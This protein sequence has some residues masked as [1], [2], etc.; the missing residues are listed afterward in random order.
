VG[1]DHHAYRVGIDESS[2]EDE[3]YQVVIE[4]DRVQ[5]EVESNLTGGCKKWNEAVEWLIDRLLLFS[6][7]LHD[8]QSAVRY[9]LASEK[10]LKYDIWR[11]YLCTVLATRT[12]PP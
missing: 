1:Y 10:Y 6:L 9:L 12:R 2:I 3:G 8:V 4:N 11:S 7:D 5:V